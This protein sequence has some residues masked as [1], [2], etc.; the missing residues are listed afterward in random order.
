MEQSDWIDV[1]IFIKAINES[2]DML[3]HAILLM[4]KNH[5]DT[6]MQQWQ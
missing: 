3:L 1:T 2:L 4:S 5:H 6:V